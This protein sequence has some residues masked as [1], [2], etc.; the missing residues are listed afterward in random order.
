MIL[1]M[2]KGGTSDTVADIISKAI[3][4]WTNTGHTMYEPSMCLSAKLLTVIEDQNAIGWD[5]FCAGFVSKQWA[6]MTEQRRSKT[7]RTPWI[8]KAFQHACQFSI[9]VWLARNEDVHGKDERT[10]R[11]IREK[12]QMV[13]IRNLYDKAKKLPH[14]YQTYF[15]RD[16]D[17]WEKASTMEMNAWIVQMKA[18]MRHH[19]SD[20]EAMRSTARQNIRRYMRTE[21]I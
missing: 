16:L 19:D 12:E 15:H 21:D 2:R 18:I 17:R 1:K 7:Y 13:A 3:T 9:E 4:N 5:N 6:T 11:N 14:K 10:V 8:T 20:K